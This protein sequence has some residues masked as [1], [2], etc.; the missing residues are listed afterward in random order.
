MKVVVTGATGFVGRSIVPRLAIDYEVYCV[1]REP[2]PELPEGVVAVGGDLVHV[3]G[4]ANLPKRADVVL[5]LAQ[6]KGAY[7]AHAH[8]LFEVNAGSTERLL[9][10][11]TGAGVSRFVLASTGS[12]YQPVRARLTESATLNP[13]LGFYALTKRLAETLALAR[14]DLDVAVLRLFAPYGPG[15]QDRLIPRLIAAVRRGEPVV[16]K[17]GGSPAVNPI[18]IDDLVEVLAQAVLGTGEGVVNVAGPRSVSI[19]D[20]A[21]LAGAAL[22]VQPLFVQDH[23]LGGDLVADISLMLATFV[24][25]DL[26]DPGVGIPRLAAEQAHVA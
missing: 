8:D 20:I 9:Q 18:W 16:L 14:E 23:E 4:L 15:Q 1:V 26:T 21:E 10:Y 25:G 11:A 22:G 7:P 6:G 3:D 5:H 12:V 24:L 17:R 13:S 2:R 19:R